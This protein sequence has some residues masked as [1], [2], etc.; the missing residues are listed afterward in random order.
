MTEVV[1][2]KRLRR[3]TSVPKTEPNNI[4]VPTGICLVIITLTFMYLYKRYKDKSR[5][6]LQSPNTLWM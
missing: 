5:Q 3:I 4:N 1:D 6:Q 2:F